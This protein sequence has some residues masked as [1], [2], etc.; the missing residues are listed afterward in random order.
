VPRQNGKGEVLMARELFGMFELG[1]M[2]IVHSAHEFKTSE[3][4][5]RGCEAVIK[6]CPELLAR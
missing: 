3:R 6:R 4:H 2:S 1:E 5:F